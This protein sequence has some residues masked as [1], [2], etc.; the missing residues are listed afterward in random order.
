MSEAPTLSGPD[1][2][3]GVEVSDVPEGGMLLGNAHGEAV[4]LVRHGREMSAVAATCTHY[5]GPLADGIVS[6]GQV[7]CPWHPA[8]SDARTGEALAPPALNP[9]RRWNVERRG[10][11]VFVGQPLA[12]PSGPKTL[13]S[14]LESVVIVGAGAAG[15]A[16]AET[17][18]REGYGGPVTL[19]GAEPT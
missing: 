10:S 12:A 16:A 13:A 17:L 8:C 7:R 11:K 3:Q 9:L 14:T 15:N 18:R 4:L 5:G 6:D 1:F 19:I 2:T